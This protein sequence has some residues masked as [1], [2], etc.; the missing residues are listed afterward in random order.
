MNVKELLR[1][2][3]IRGISRAAQAFRLGMNAA[4][5]VSLNGACMIGELPHL[6]EVRAACDAGDF[7]R[8]ADVLEY[9]CRPLL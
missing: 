9:K 1:P 3:F 4:G 5:I 7:L 2:E 8:A 6:E